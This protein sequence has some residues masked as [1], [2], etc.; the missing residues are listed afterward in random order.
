MSY[1]LGTELRFAMFEDHT[2]LQQTNFAVN[3]R[4]NRRYDRGAELRF[5]MYGCGAGLRFF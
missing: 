1:N 3:T 5:L 4:Y 2:G